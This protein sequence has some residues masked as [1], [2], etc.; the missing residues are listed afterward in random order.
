MY[1]LDRIETP[2]CL[3]SKQ[4][5]GSTPP[6]RWPSRCLG[7]GDLATRQTGCAAASF[8][9]TGRAHAAGG[10]RSN[11]HARCRP[12][13]GDGR[14]KSNGP[15]CRYSPRQWH[16]TLSRRL[17]QMLT[18]IDAGLPD[19]NRYSGRRTGNRQGMDQG[20]AAIPR[21]VREPENPERGEGPPRGQPQEAGVKPK[22]LLNPRRP[23][24]CR[25]AR[26][27]R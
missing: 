15:P 7:D 8:Q 16:G 6:V 21:K 22:G 18:E 20:R 27:A 4:I 5:E 23:R 11:P 1:S 25:Q 10:Q 26:R 19:G 12:D 3:L 17:N 24:S 14:E 2:T 13:Q 9:Q